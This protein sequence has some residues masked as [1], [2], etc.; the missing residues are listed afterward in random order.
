M[1]SESGF[2]RSINDELHSQDIQEDKISGE[3]G[4]TL[5]DIDEYHF[6]DI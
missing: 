3:S 5:S 1:E 4:V 2:S 6:W